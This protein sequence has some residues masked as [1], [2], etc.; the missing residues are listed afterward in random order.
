[1]ERTLCP[2]M[3]YPALLAPQASPPVRNCLR[4]PCAWW[5]P[6]TDGG[7]CSIRAIAISISYIARQQAR[8]SK[9]VPPLEQQA[10]LVPDSTGKET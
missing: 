1:M 6:S 2:L 8:Q 4:G 9:Q 7:M 5:V 10:P 3:L